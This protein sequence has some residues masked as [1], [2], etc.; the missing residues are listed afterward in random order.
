[1]FE[2]TLCNVLSFQNVLLWFILENELLEFENNCQNY[3]V[4]TQSTFG[5][6]S[7]QDVLR[8]ST[9]IFTL[10]YLIFFKEI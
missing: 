8:I 6:L 3:D 7:S 9:Y 10:K 4:K 1:M 2:L 5:Q